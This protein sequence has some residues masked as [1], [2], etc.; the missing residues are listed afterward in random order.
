M[1]SLLSFLICAALTLPVF[2]DNQEMVCNGEKCTD[3]TTTSLSGE[4]SLENLWTHL[5]KKYS[6]MTEQE[7]SNFHSLMSRINDES[8]STLGFIIS[9]N[10]YKYYH[11]FSSDDDMSSYSLFHLDKV[12]T[13]LLAVFAAY[14]I[15]SFDISIRNYM[16]CRRAIINNLHS[17]IDDY[18]SRLDKYE[19]R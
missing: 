3:K 19:K 5:S 18:R 6:S 13:S 11:C 17:S 4:E 12:V 9:K 16:Q 7:K 1:K 8:N 15:I 14:S 2:A 10:E